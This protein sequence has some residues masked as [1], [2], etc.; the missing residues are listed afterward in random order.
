MIVGKLPSWLINKITKVVAPQ[1][2]K[3][4]RKACNEYPKWKSQTRPNHKPWR[5]PEQQLDFPRINAQEMCVPIDYQQKI[6][7]ETKID[8]N[9]VVK[10]ADE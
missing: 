4:L 3:R 10:I 1:V 6:L 9:D 5:Y 2:L 8:E 7:D